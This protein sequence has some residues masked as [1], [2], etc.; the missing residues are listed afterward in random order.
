MDV[1]PGPGGN[2]ESHVDVTEVAPYVYYRIA[3]GNAEGNT[4][5]S[6]WVLAETSGDSDPSPPD[7]GGGPGK[8]HPKKGCP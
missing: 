7:G 8:C 2:P 5:M 3:A 6:P 4:V 1:V